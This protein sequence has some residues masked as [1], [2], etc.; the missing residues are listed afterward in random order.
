MRIVMTSR[1]I[2]LFLF[3]SPV[4]SNH[5]HKSPSQKKPSPAVGTTNPRPRRSCAPAYG[6][7]Q[8]PTIPERRLL[9]V[10]ALLCAPVLFAP[11]THPADIACRGQWKQRTRVMDDPL[12][13]ERR[14]VV[15][16]VSAS[17]GSGLR[18]PEHAAADERAQS[19]RRPRAATPRA[20]SPLASTRCSR[21]ASSDMRRSVWRESWSSAVE[22]ARAPG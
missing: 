10:F 11:D 13:V 5:L 22:R 7:P 16:R 8:G 21:C 17:R 14:G 15:V 20:S 2:L 6:R 4:H 19:S 9:R 18:S 3:R 1:F 12:A